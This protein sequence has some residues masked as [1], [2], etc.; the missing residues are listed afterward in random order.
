LEGAGGGAL[1]TV[2]SEGVGGRLR[3]LFDGGDVAIP[4][5]GASEVSDNFARMQ[6][7]WWIGCKSEE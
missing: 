1:G 7:R 6:G 5:Y 3:G 2:R 4:R